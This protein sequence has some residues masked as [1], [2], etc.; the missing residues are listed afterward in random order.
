MVPSDLM[1]ISYLYF[2]AREEVEVVAR[3]AVEVVAP[4]EVDSASRVQ[5]LV[6]STFSFMYG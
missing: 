3:V 4:G 2:A 6:A 1:T 5:T